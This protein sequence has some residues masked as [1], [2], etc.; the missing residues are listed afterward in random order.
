MISD[1][2]ACDFYIRLSFSFVFHQ[3]HAVFISFLAKSDLLIRRKVSNNIRS[4]SR[5]SCIILDQVIISFPGML[6]H[7]FGE[8]LEL[9]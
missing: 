1:H 9:G 6:L 4:V 3:F 7:L 5:F 2:I 8:M